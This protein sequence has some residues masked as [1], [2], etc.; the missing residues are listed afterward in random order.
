MSVPYPWEV[1]WVEFITDLV[2]PALTWGILVV[3]VVGLLALILHVA[4]VK[5]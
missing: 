2:L 5:M 3:A 1:K 4:Q